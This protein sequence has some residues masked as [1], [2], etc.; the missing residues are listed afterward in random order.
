MRHIRLA[1]CFELRH[2]QSGHG[3]PVPG[4]AESVQAELAERL[5]AEPALVQ[6]GGGH[7]SVGAYRFDD[8]AGEVGMEAFLLKAGDGSVLHVPLTYRGAP[9]A[10]AE[11]FLIGTIEHSVL[12]RRWVY[13]GCGDPV[14]ATALA[15]TVLT[16]GTQVEEFVDV[17][18][19]VEATATVLGSGTAGTQVGEIDA[20][21]VHDKGLTTLIRTDLLELVVI[22]VVGA[23]VSA[24]QTLTGSWS[25]GEPVVLAGARPIQSSRP[26]AAISARAGPS[27]ER[28]PRTTPDLGRTPVP[29]VQFRAGH[30]ARLC[31]MP[32]AGRPQ[33]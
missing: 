15:K 26:G 20:V 30:S 19:R 7:R 33:R 14:W 8:P 31:R 12:G 1:A 25:G 3:H 4:D 23:A 18:G 9:L 32:P 13:D 17:D 16:G 21:S 29:S 10:G 5:A 24:A 11:E 27:H 6:R 28:R 22:R 2:L